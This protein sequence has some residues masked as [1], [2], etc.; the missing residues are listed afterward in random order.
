MLDFFFI[1][2]VF[3]G[4][5]IHLWLIVIVLQAILTICL[6][7]FLFFCLKHVFGLDFA[8]SQYFEY[9]KCLTIRN[10][11]PR[12]FN[13]NTARKFDQNLLK[14]IKLFFYLYIIGFCVIFSLI[15][16]VDP[17]GKIHLWMTVAVLNAILLLCLENF[18]FFCLKP[19]CGL[20][21]TGFS[22][23]LNI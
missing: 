16:L 1:F 3:P 20:E 23:F 14:M 11:E 15:F 4:R 5:K 9:L 8:L 10:K 6:Q 2:S 7:D 12:K 22:Y 18:L 21:F 13:L 19:V 17:D